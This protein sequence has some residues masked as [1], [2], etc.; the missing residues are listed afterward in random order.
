MYSTVRSDGFSN[1]AGGQSLD[2]K[3]WD[4][5]LGGS[6]SQTWSFLN[7]WGGTIRGAT[8]GGVIEFV[9]DGDRN[10]RSS[11]RLAG[12]DK[13]G[14]RFSFRLN[15]SGNCSAYPRYNPSGGT[16][17]NHNQSGFAA[18]RLLLVAG[19]TAKLRFY[20]NNTGTGGNGEDASSYHEVNLG[21]ENLPSTTWCR[22]RVILSDMA[23]SIKYSVLIVR[24]SDGFV[25]TNTMAE[26]SNTKALGCRLSELATESAYVAI[27]GR[28]GAGVALMDNFEVISTQ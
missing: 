24:E 20:S 22:A 14:L 21:G 15:T 16:G 11:S 7:G 19:S 9:Q 12:A 10:A 23:S 4:N 17:D 18:V 6:G 27:R 1:V 25:Y 5:A 2:S 26:S 3:S 28:E 8:G 13:M